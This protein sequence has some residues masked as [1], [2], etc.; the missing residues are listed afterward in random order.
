MGTE[1][2]IPR[3]SR[4]SPC[5]PASALITIKCSFLKAGFA[6][7]GNNFHWEGFTSWEQVIHFTSISVYLFLPFNQEVINR[8]FG[9][10]KL[11]TLSTF[12][13]ERASRMNLHFAHPMGIPHRPSQGSRAPGWLVSISLASTPLPSFT[14]QCCVYCWLEYLHSPPSPVKATFLFQAFIGFFFSNP[15]VCSGTHCL[16]NRSNTD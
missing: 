16:N 14:R 5:N 6:L 4:L 11:E 12:Q 1:R 9:K 3:A 13:C 7:P 15:D 10:I 8:C 2:G